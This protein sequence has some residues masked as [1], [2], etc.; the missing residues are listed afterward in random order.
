MITLRM[1]KMVAVVALAVMRAVTAGAGE[2]QDPGYRALVQE[3]RL[4]GPGRGGHD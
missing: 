4:P 3:F 1:S 2:E